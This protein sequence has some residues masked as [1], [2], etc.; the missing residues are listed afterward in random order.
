MDESIYFAGFLDGIDQQIDIV[1]EQLEIIGDLF[2][3]ADRRRH[4]EHLGAGFAADR[5]RGLQV[6]V[7]FDKHQLDVR[8][9]HLIDEV[10]R[11]LRCG[12]N[13]RLGFDVPDDVEAKAFGKIRK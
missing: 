5:V 7:G 4:H 6:E 13:A 1:V 10:E 8:S 12:R 3:A 11:V 9:L 2:D